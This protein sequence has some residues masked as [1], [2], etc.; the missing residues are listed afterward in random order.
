MRF[1]KSKEIFDKIKRYIFG[2]VNSLICVFKNLNIILFVI[3]KGRGCFIFD[4]DGNKYID[5]VLFWGVMILGYCDFDVVNSIKE[6]V[7]E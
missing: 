1:D 7:V 4:V 5:F 2:G 6:V 3:L